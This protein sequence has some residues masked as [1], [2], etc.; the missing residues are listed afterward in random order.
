MREAA[1][2]LHP[3]PPQWAHSVKQTNLIFLV[4]AFSS[5]GFSEVNAGIHKY[6]KKPVCVIQF[7]FPAC[8][9]LSLRH[10]Y[11]QSTDIGCAVRLVR[12]NEIHRRDLRRATSVM[13]RPYR[14]LLRIFTATPER[15]LF[16]S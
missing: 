15:S 3:V 2:N 16:E 11:G 13:A 7:C 9:W 1:S 6:E 8:L 5:R 12:T 4:T 14:S 10:R